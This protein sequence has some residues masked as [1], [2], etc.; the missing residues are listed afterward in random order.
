M[1]TLALVNLYTGEPRLSETDRREQLK[2]LIRRLHARQ[3][4]TDD[5]PGTGVLLDDGIR[6]YC[7]RFDLITPFRPERGLLKPAN[8]KLCVGDEYAIGAVRGSL[9]AE[10][11]KNTLTIPPFQVAVIKT[12]EI[13]NMPRFL[14]GRWNIQVQRAYQGLLWVGGPQVDAGYIGHLFCPV[15]NLSDQPVP[16]EYDEPFAVIDFVKTT[17]FHEHKSKPYAPIPPERILIEDYPPLRSALVTQVTDK[18]DAFKERVEQ[19]ESETSTRVDSLQTRIDFF[20]SIT[21][22]VI[23][24]LFAAVT[25]ASNKPENVH[26]WWQPGLLWVWVVALSMAL[27]AW[28]RSRS[29][30]RWTRAVEIVIWIAVL[31]ALVVQATSEN[32]QIKQL[33]DEIQ[34]LRQASP[35]PQTKGSPSPSK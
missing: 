6:H 28:V 25:V 33:R 24:L 27:L 21:F 18:L 29:P 8:Y 4:E 5:F 14:I 9:S 16:L 32:M 26:A 10:S 13:I 19:V 17:E 30:G 20:V 2:Q 34:Q 35:P 12:F 15:Y 31:A 1:L 3:P 22:A 11:G 23:A 7:N